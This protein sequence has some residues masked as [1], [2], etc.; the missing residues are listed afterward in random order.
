MSIIYYKNS[1][2]IE[3]A[4]LTDTERQVYENLSFGDNIEVNSAFTSSIELKY[5]GS[6]D[7]RID[8]K[9]LKNTLKE[10][11]L[12]SNNFEYSNFE[13]TNLKIVKIPS[14]FYGSKIQKGTVKL[15]YYVT[16]TLVA[17]LED[18]SERGE[19]ITT[20]HPTT[21][22]SIEG[23]VLYNHGIILLTGSSNIGTQQDYFL[24]ISSG[25]LS[26][27]WTYYGETN[28]DTVSSSFDLTFKGTTYTPNIMMFAHADKGEL[29]HTNNPTA[30]DTLQVTTGSKGYYEQENT[31]YVNT[32]KSPFTKDEAD[33]KK[34]VFITKLGIYDKDRNL[35]G[36]AK[37][38]SPLKKTED[39]EFIFK[40]K[41][42]L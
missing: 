24:G 2:Q 3:P 32:V 27:N 22:G 34:Q 12:Y 17:R 15:D 39:R 18:A 7:D 4:K 31:G 6:S 8:I 13:T 21:T 14:V 28:T 10:Y 38:A 23:V 9:A 40:I 33:F 11:Q 5:I 19:L 30:Y 29:N 35:I 1:G 26:Y 41:L 20:Y 42:D 36:I 25:S 16:G 37:L